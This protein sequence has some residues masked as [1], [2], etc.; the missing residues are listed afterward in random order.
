MA[1][2]RNLGLLLVLSV[3]G[4][5]VSSG[6]HDALR[7]HLDDTRATLTGQ[8]AERD[9]RITTLEGE[10]AALRATGE[11]HGAEIKRLEVERARLESDLA[12]VVKDRAQLKESADEMRQA[13][14]ESNRRKAEADKRL[15][16]YRKLLSQLKTMI[17][18][19]K[20]KVKLVD[21]R[22]VL[23]LPSD[24]LFASGSAELS[25]AGQQAIAEVTHILLTIAD[26]RFQVEGHTDNVPIR[27][28]R[29][30]SNWE[31]GAARAITIVNTMVA[32][33]MNHSRL[34]GASY[35]E[36]RPAAGNDTPEGRAQN[37]RIEIVVVPDLS[38]LP[39]FDELTRA[40]EGG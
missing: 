33:G 4:A 23:A 13:L 15:A 2:T 30:P 29:F 25:P 21:G 28:A 14:A 8:L 20:L 35:G 26:R 36:Y 12:G 37:R 3:A 40:V 18:A 7:K 5:C 16:E 39:G 31:L 10:I 1:R 19:G 17:D 34:S 24:V 27:T 38:L 32:T 11:E 6:K 22:M 9:K